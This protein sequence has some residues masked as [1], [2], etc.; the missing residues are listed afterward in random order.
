MTVYVDKPFYRVGRMVMCHMVAD[1]LQELHAMADLI[2]VD[3]RHF[4]SDASTP[5]YDVC[6]QMRAVAVGAGAREVNRREM[7]AVIRRLRQ[8]RKS[9]TTEVASP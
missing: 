6:K 2:G 1:T 5:H 9:P 8:Q 4:Q 7:V 3:R